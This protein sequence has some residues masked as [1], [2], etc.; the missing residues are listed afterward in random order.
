[1]PRPTRR[2]GRASS[3]PARSR[4]F[5]GDMNAQC[6]LLALALLL[7]A[8]GAAGEALYQEASFRALTAD[9]RAYRV[10]DLLTVLVVENA[11]ASQTA[12]TATDK[13]GGIGVSVTNVGIAPKRPTVSANINLNDNFEG[14]GRIQRSGRL[15]AQLSV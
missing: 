15:L 7:V 12:D 2:T 8:H 11:S 14:K 6:R 3:R 5:G 10:G 1:M 13:Q 4:P 9:P